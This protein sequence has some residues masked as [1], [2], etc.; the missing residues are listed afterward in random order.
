MNATVVKIGGSLSLHPKTLKTLC[1]TLSE[2]NKTNKLIL[3][4]GGGEFADVVRE[5]DKRFKLSSEAAHR[6][7]V[8][9]M[10]QYGF[11]LSDLV[12]DF[13]VVNK[14]ED[15]QR[16]LNLNKV[17]VFLPSNLML[18]QDPLM[19]SWDVTSDSIAAYIANQLNIKRVILI[20]DVD[21][22]YT[23]DPKKYSDAKLI[24]RLSAR[25]L[26]KMHKRTSVDKYLPSLL[27][28]FQLQC[29]VVNG[30]YPERV[31]AVLE[32]KKDICT[33]IN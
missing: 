10:D 24:E 29:I 25:Q 23:K 6:M 32:G 16:I 31:E 17:P 5:A 30:L 7:A 8:L 13:Y 15:V 28:K 26:E 14:L 2:A 9:G 33:I 21:G 3:V 22:V 20:T 18:N 4:P 19:N 12:A 1:E 27:L 11:L